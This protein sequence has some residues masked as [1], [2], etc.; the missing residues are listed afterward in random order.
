VPGAAVALGRVVGAHGL[1]GGIR[2]RCFAEADEGVLALRRVALGRAEDDAQAQ[3]FEV[4]A[5]APGRP[6]E[7]R[8]DLV[9]VDTREAAEALRGRL[10]LV[11]PAELGPLAAGEYYGYQ[12]LG[13]RVEGEDGVA[14][15]TV[16]EI[17]ATGASDLLVVEG[18]GGARHLIPA[19][20]LRRLDA[21]ARRIV[22]E[23][24]PGLL[25]AE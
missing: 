5:V 1:R 10:V 16:R 7:L 24:P 2:V 20:F 8:V 11:A 25:A 14:V 4:R 23:I 13:C 21:G 12:L 18:E 9:G 22:V 6:G 19:A 15:G 3:A 17:W